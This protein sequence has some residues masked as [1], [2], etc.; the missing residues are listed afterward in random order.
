MTNAIQLL[1]IYII[2]MSSDKSIFLG[3]AAPLA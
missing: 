1:M 2:I 3:P